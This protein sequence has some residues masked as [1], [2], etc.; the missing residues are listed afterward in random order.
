MAAARPRLLVTR[1]LE[2]ARRFG[3]VAAAAGFDVTIE[4]MS[5][6]EATPV[7]ADVFAGV[8]AVLLT[9]AAA[10]APLAAFGLDADLPVLTVGDATAAAARAAGMRAVESADGD[11]NA[12]AALAAERLDPA[13]GPVAHAAGERRAGDLAG[14]LAAMG[15][16]ARTVVLYRAVPATRLT[17]ETAAALRAG[18]IAYAAFFSPQTARTFVSLAESSGIA[19]NFSN[20][21]AIAL[22]PNVGEALGKLN[23]RRVLTAE[24]PNADALLRKLVASHA[25][26]APEDGAGQAG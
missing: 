16:D 10:V 19:R 12:L 24:R 21:T 11:V 18:E 8:Q 14:A 4:P 13:A 6:I 5:I 1:P 26:A 22:S 23:W 2:G 3:Q 17:P 15:F 7:S 20:A 25:D 9:S